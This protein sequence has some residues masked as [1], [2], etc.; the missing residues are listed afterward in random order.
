MC[1]HSL[2]TRLYLKLLVYGAPQTHN[3][4]LNRGRNRISKLK[5]FISAPQHYADNATFKLITNSAYAPHMTNS[6]F[7][8]CSDEYYLVKSLTVSPFK[9]GVYFSL[10]VKKVNLH[11]TVSSRHCDGNHLHVCLCHRATQKLF[12]Y[13]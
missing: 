4:D 3:A 6:I 2:C 5:C 12:G 13:D 10:E 11:T 1:N 8:Q 7:C 9:D